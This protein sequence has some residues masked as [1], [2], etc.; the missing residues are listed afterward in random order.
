[1]LAAWQLLTSPLG[2]A[3]AAIVVVLLVG[4]GAYWKGRADRAALDRSA[5]LAAQVEQLKA[6]IASRERIAAAARETVARLEEEKAQD[7]EL[8]AGYEDELAKREE[9]A[10]RLSPADVERL[11]NGAAPGPAPK[12]AGAPGGAG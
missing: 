4:T 8:I 5:L 9:P 3:L 7:D 12:P 10:C 2:R 6:D 11:R 1:M